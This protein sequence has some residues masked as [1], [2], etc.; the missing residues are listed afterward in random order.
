[1]RLRPY[2]GPIA[3]QDEVDR[4]VKVL[5]DLAIELNNSDW[6][7]SVVC[8]AKGNSV[9]LHIDFRLLNSFTIPDA[10]SIKIGQDLLFKGGKTNFITVLDLIKVYWQIPMK[11]EAKPY[12]AIVTHS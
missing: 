3:L 10:Y 4:Q 8:V 7:H 6:A 1:M 11:E 9:R 2:R 5:F 12:I